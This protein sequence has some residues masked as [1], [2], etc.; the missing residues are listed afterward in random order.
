MSHLETIERRF[1]R[2]SL[3]SFETPATEQRVQILTTIPLHF[4]NISSVSPDA[5]I[6]WSDF[7]ELAT[8]SGD[9][10]CHGRN[11]AVVATTSRE[12]SLK[13]T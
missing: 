8:C 7:V 12:I 6:S 11:A 10:E 2:V 4:H 1:Y 5:N 13:R 3:S 9:I